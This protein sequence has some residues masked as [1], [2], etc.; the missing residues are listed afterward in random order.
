MRQIDGWPKRP[1]I[2]GLIA[3]LAWLP[4]SLSATQ[5]Q[6]QGA[7]AV[8][9]NSRE[10]TLK[11]QKTLRQQMVQFA[12][13]GRK[14]QAIEAAQHFIEIE[15]AIAGENTHEMAFAL[16][17]LAELSASE[18]DSAP[19]LEYLRKA[20]EAETKIHGEDHWHVT[21]VRGETNYVQAVSKL[22]A[23]EREAFEFATAVRPPSVFFEP[24]PRPGRTATGVRTLPAGRTL[25]QLRHAL[26]VLR[27]SVGENV[28][29]Y[30]LALEQ[31]AES[32]QSDGNPFAA[33]IWAE[34]CLA[35]RERVEG[36]RHPNYLRAMELRAA[37][38]VELAEYQLAR[39][40]LERA[41]VI[42][43]E[44]EDLDPRQNARLEEDLAL[45]LSAVGELDG[46]VRA[47]AN[48]AVLTLQSDKEGSPVHIRILAEHCIAAGRRNDFA[49]ARELWD[50]VLVYG[51]S[52]KPEVVNGYQ[53]G[54]TAAAF[55]LRTHGDSEGSLILYRA[56]RG[57]P[58]SG[59]MRP[60][61]PHATGAV[62]GQA[63]AEVSGQAEQLCR[64][65][66]FDEAVQLLESQIAALR[67]APDGRESDLV[68]YAL[69]HLANTHLARGDYTG[70]RKA[71][72]QRF[73]TVKGIT[74]HDGHWQVIDARLTLAQIERLE[75]LPPDRRRRIEEVRWLA[76]SAVVFAAEG[77]FDAASDEFRRAHSLQTELMGEDDPDALDLL[78]DLVTSL[79]LAKRDSEAETVAAKA[80]ALNR[81]ARGPRH[82]A[83]VFC[84]V[85]LA[86]IRKS[87]GNLRGARSTLLEAAEAKRPAQGT[88]RT[89]LTH[90]WG[91]QTAR[92]T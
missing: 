47:Y 19:A 52:S 23:D 50:R 45:V 80:L 40:I 32:L 21:D 88:G 12:G 46:A 48:A 13:Q 5:G 16:R 42:A 69:E 7:G 3:L 49:A 18:K 86:W 71:A 59:L 51:R 57:D 91:G 63:Y 10:E 31:L 56:A 1:A 20:L 77:L 68:V 24:F 81:G 33:A 35:A 62:R 82:P 11:R 9:D 8:K 87:R 25:D 72:E 27:R 75:R 83:T 53:I 14:A 2:W 90:V 65:G 17:L 78:S 89:L 58:E 34:R 55:K 29:R 74:A 60:G 67:K 61:K 66:K 44:I 85:R 70:A 28:P 37:L 41:E 15:R 54:L 84:S 92:A 39:P 26:F 30:C 43:R 36:R 22:P 38:H 73:Q 79:S 76:D 6:P 64:Q 4:P